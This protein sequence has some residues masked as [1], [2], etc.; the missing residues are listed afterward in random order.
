VQTTV[1]VDPTD[2]L[3]RAKR[4]RLTASGAEGG[5]VIDAND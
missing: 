4:V 5:E 3:P 1:R 2:D